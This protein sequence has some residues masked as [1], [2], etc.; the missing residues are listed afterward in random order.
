MTTRQETMKFKIDNRKIFAIL[1]LGFIMALCCLFS[2]WKLDNETRLVF[3]VFSGFAGL[4]FILIG[5]LIRSR[6][7]LTNDYLILTNILRIGT[8]KILLS[9]IERTKSIYK[10]FPVTAHLNNPLWL[11][12]WDKKFKRI[13]KLELF[14]KGKLIGKIDGHFLEDS[15]YEKLKRKLK[16]RKPAHNTRYIP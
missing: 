1:G 2:F 6:Y 3:S 8:K 9:D 5:L 14:R 12:L 7:Y 10:E 15:E 11:L 4:L 16:R 13:I